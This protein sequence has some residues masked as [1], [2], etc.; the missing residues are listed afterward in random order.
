MPRA[1]SVGISVESRK[2]SLHLALP[3]A[4]TAPLLR[5]SQ[6]LPQAPQVGTNHT[7][8]VFVTE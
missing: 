7:V 8:W 3:P 2:A 1:L 5:G 6:E 4:R